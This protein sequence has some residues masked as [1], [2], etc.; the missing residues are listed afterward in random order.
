MFPTKGLVI[1]LIRIN[2]EKAPPPRE[3]LHPNSF[4]SA[5]K[6]TEKEYQTP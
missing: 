1:A 6:K 5:T 2:E 3:R 4:K